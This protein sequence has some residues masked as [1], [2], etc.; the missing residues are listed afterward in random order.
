MA[1]IMSLPQEVIDIIL[2]YND[3]SFEDIINFRCVS[4]IFQ[5]VAKHH[6]FMEKKF[7]QRWPTARKFY[8]KQFKENEQEEF[9][10]KNNKESLHFIEIGINCAR[11][12][13]YS[14]S[15]KIQKYYSHDILIANSTHY[16]YIFELD[17][18]IL[19]IFRK[20]KDD[21]KISFYIDEIKNLLI[22][23]SRKIVCDL[24]E[25]YYNI[26]LFNCLK[27]RM[28]RIKF[29]KFEKQ[30]QK[31][32]LLERIAIIMAQKFQ[33]QKDV[34]YS[35]VTT[36]LDN[37]GIEILN[38]LKEK[39]PD[40]PIFSMS[41]ENF[42]YWKKHNIG[43]NYWNEAEGTQIMD[44]LEEYIFGKLNF[45]PNKSGN[46]EWN[47]Q[48]K[49]KCIDHVL[50]YKYSQEIIIYIIYHSVARRLGLRCNIIMGYP[51]KRI[52][53]FW[54]PSYATNNLENVRCFR[55]N[56]NKFPD[57]FIKQQRFKRLEVITADQMGG[58]LLDL[59][60]F[61]EY[62]W[63]INLA[64]SENLRR[65]NFNWNMNLRDWSTSLRKIE[66]HCTQKY[67]FLVI[68]KDSLLTN[69]R[70]RNRCNVFAIPQND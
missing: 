58:I 3:I 23:F 12:L 30:P 44:T 11:R 51:S 38:S 65:N 4:K 56:S 61:N 60:K 45:R 27:Q 46:V 20:N 22:E 49:Y 16:T 53:L 37:M 5:H 66:P 69:G 36:S 62:L 35:S 19:P 54:K 2:G 59:I 15:Q 55:I 26:Q 32:Q 39:H 43:D 14:M 63:K 29:I 33:P 17:E 21:I 67:G 34:L 42:S 40:H 48:L 10:E 70:Y 68:D 13:R 31:M 41:A 7:F 24:T 25:K 8:N 6:K 9:E 1:T 57:C 18:D 50:E 52:C 47:I 64:S 28:L